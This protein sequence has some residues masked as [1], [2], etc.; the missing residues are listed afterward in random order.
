MAAQAYSSQVLS[1]GFAVVPRV[2]PDAQIVASLDSIASLDT[3]ESIRRRGGIFAVRN[4]LDISPAFRELAESKFVRD[5]VVPFLGES[6]FP[7]RGILFDKTPQANWKVPW[8]QDVTIAV[9]QRVDVEGFGRRS[10]MVELA[11]AV[12][13]IAGTK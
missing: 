3:H 6:A 1:E 13:C 7:V 9:E 2:L 8:H 5:L 12:F 4:F 11:M 10:Q